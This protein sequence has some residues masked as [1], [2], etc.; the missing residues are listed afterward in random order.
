[1]TV[2]QYEQYQ[3]PKTEANKWKSAVFHSIILLQNVFC[4]KRS[5]NGTSLSEIRCCYLLDMLVILYLLVC[6]SASIS[7]MQIYHQWFL[8][9]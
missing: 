1:M 6:Y 4:N 8:T 5:V 7:S 2:S 3:D 9:Y